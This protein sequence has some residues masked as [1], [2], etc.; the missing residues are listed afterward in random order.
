MPRVKFRSKTILA[1][2]TTGFYFERPLGFQ[3]QAGQFGDWTLIDPPTTDAE[4]NSRTF[5]I[6]SAPAERDLMI[7]TR[8]RDTALKPGDKGGPAVL[9]SLAPAGSSYTNRRFVDNLHHI[10]KENPHRI[11][12][13]ARFG[14]LRYS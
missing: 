5:T 3:F 8:M 4:G 11:R 7:A 6:A 10:V 2:G 13:A 1:E 14:V 9:I 12:A